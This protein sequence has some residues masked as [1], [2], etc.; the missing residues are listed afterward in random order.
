[1]E[2]QDKE[3]HEILPVL[4]VK[5]TV[6]FPNM[7]IPVLLKNEKVLTMIEEVTKIEGP[8]LVVMRQ[9][10]EKEGADS[11]GGHSVGTIATVVKVSKGEEGTLALVQGISRAA[12]EE[13]ASHDPFVMAKVRRLT[14]A[15]KEGQRMDAL[16][17]NLLKQDR[18]SVV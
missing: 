9:E 10:G 7:V 5:D 18:K 14:D 17:A 4:P 16:K 11:W 3:H 8:V 12:V 1:M 15:K 13:I 6:L 2:S